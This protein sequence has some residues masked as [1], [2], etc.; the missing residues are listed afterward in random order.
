MTEIVRKELQHD[1]LLFVPCSLSPETVNQFNFSKSEIVQG[2]CCWITSVACHVLIPGNRLQVGFL[3]MWS[4][5]NEEQD[6][7]PQTNDSTEFNHIAI[8]NALASVQHIFPLHEAIE[9][10]SIMS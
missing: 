1:R 8:P 5:Q 10:L 7:R 6:K 2:T 4:S 9:E 3:V